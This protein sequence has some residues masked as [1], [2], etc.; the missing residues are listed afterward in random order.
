M[1]VCAL[2]GWD[3][4]YCQCE[5]HLPLN[6]WFFFPPKLVF[7]AVLLIESILLTDLSDKER[8]HVK[9]IVLNSKV[10]STL[11][12]LQLHQAEM[13]PWLG[14]RSHAPLPQLFK[15]ILKVRFSAF[16]GAKWSY[17][18]RA[19]NKGVI[20]LLLPTKSTMLFFHSQIKVVI[21]PPSAR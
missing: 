2:W 20:A 15:G 9:I 4:C 21:W 3:V 18:N 8:W 1:C 19:E 6:G 14:F 11:I 13:S 17:N 16:R 5:L 10:L 12:M 7:C